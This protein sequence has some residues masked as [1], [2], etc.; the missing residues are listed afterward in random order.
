MNIQI[1]LR[2]INNREIENGDI[3]EWDDSEG[4]RTAKVIISPYGVS[5]YCF[6]N[7]IPDNWAVGQYF[8]LQSFIYKDTSRHLKI[9]K[10]WNEKEG[11][12]K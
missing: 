2:D 5:F 6:K 3:V 11:E 7:S 4:T 12:S 10:K 9:I 1:N 8:D